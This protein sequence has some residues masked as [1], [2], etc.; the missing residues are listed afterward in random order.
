[1]IF[2]HIPFKSKQLRNPNGNGW[3]ETKKVRISRDGLKAIDK[4]D[5]VWPLYAKKGFNIS[6]GAVRK[7]DN[8][9][10]TILYY[11]EVTRTRASKL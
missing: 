2:S 4:N 7:K 5:D 6:A 10:G 8:Y 1:M 3:K 9:P 11:Y